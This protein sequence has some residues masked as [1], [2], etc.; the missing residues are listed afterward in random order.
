MSSYKYVIVGGGMTA[1]SAVRGIR[2]IDQTGSI[3]L[4]GDEK[5]PPYNRPPLSKAL[6]KGD[7]VDSIWR[8]TDKEDV[9]F[10][11][12]THVASINPS[13]KEITAENG[14]SYN[15]E[16]LLIATG[17]SPR[18]LSL[19]EA[20]QDRNAKDVIYFRTFRDFEILHAISIRAS[21]FLVIGGGFIGSEVAAAL[22]MNEKN[23]TMIFPDEGIGA[24]VYPKNLS[25]Y[26][27]TY[28]RER[29][30]NVIP[31]DSVADVEERDGRFVVRS[32]KG[33]RL[34]VNAVV[35]GL[36]IIPNVGLA[37]K[38]GIAVNNG[39]VVD[40]FLRTTVP[41]IFAAGD[42]ASFYNPFLEKRM[43]VEHED[44]A[45]AM[46]RVAGQNM[47]GASELYHHIPFFYSDLFELGYEAVGE[48]DSRLEIFEDWEEEFRKG[49]LYYLND[50]R[51]RGVLLWNTWG[52]VDAARELMVSRKKFSAA[53]LRGLIRD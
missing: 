16:K 21:D 43:R 4:F 6:W 12:G 15:F 27:L 50:G 14:S 34:S 9:A 44:N 10:F 28:F 45:N 3:G 53:A 29:G 48:L 47:A 42:V 18:R 5:E 41:D 39:I 13:A 1:D 30:V 37:T 40:E 31:K 49:V 11:L 32:K 7:P 17:G 36:G 38:A 33:G 22:S 35:A 24:K 20:V 8:G 26:L 52:K 23:V 51:I 19:E 46:G 2:E 25:S